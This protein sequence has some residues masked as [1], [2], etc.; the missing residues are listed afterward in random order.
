[1][2]FP[3]KLTLNASAERATLSSFPNVRF[4]MARRGPADEPRTRLPSLGENGTA[5]DAG[6]ARCNRWYTLDD[7]LRTSFVDDFS[8]VCVL[9]A[10][11]VAR[12][13]VGYDKPV[14]LVQ[15]AVGGT[16]VEAWMS[17]DALDVAS[18]RVLS[19][20]TPIVPPPA[21]NAVNE[22]S[23]LYNGM[24]APFDAMSV[25]AV[26]WY[27][28][29]ANADQHVSSEDA[30]KGVTQTGYYDAYLRSMI[31]D[32]RSRKGM[33]DVSFFVVS[34]YVVSSLALALFDPRDSHAS[35]CRPPSCASDTPIA[36]QM[37]TGR[38]DIRL[39]QFAMSP[40]PNG[41]VDISGVPVTTELGGASAWG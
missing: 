34:L 6:D 35:R 41:S 36:M 9:S 8:A 27:Q 20:H 25:R 38:T 16:R 5:C 17:S 33:G 15:S 37:K 3:L 4:F 24:I 29:E 1:M 39:A 12:L 7:A 18:R 21:S 13:H 11:D 23:V 10:R 19:N 2:V 31:E 30:A 26:L 22:R 32:W 40:H 14:G 28:G